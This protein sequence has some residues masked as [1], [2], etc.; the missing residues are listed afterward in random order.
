[1]LGTVT[2]L[3]KHTSLRR[4]YVRQGMLVGSISSYMADNLDAMIVAG[5]GDDDDEQCDDAYDGDDV[6]STPGPRSL[7]SVRLAARKGMRFL[8]KVE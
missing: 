6:G 3:D 4:L 1:M 7:S 2:G 8:C 5:D